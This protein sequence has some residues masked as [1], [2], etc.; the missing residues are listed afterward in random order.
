MTWFAE[1]K[2][3]PD[4]AEHECHADTQRDTSAVR[5]RG[6]Q[7]LLGPEIGICA[8]CLQVVTAAHGLSREHRGHVTEPITSHLMAARR[9]MIVYKPRETREVRRKPGSSDESIW[10]AEVKQG[11]RKRSARLTLLP[12]H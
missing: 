11:G 1:E 7:E 4:P 3:L 9:A 10:S 2:A 6:A 5:G 12:T 8:T